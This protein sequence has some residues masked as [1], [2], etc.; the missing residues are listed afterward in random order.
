MSWARAPHYRADTLAELTA[1]VPDGEDGALC[2]VKE[3]KGL[4]VLRATDTTPLPAAGYLPSKS[5]QNGA[6]PGRWVTL[7]LP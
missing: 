6:S 7:P 1:E 2:Y 4:R 5:S 3:D